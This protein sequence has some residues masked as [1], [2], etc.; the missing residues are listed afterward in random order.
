[1]DN[2]Y[3]SD[4]PYAM[5]TTM[6]GSGMSGSAVGG[7][8][9]SFAGGMGA[10]STAPVKDVTT[11]TFMT[12]VID[13][14][15]HGPVVV[16]FW[17]PWCG[18]CKDL[19]PV[20]ERVVTEVAATGRNITLAKMDV[21][22]HPQV[23]QQMGIQSIPAVV[24]FVDGRPAE[25]FMGNKP[26]AEVRA[27]IE[28][29][30]GPTTVA[31]DAAALMEEADRAVV[32]K[33]HERAAEIYAAVLA[34]EPGNL[35]AFAGLGQ[36]YIAVGEPDMAAALL[37]KI[38]EEHHAEGPL[39]SL[40]KA[41]D[42]ARQAADLGDLG[43]LAAAVEA[44]PD[45]H[46]ARFDYALALNGHGEREQATQ[47]LVAIVKADR[48]WREDGARTQLLEF[49]ETWGPMDPA[50]KAGRRALSSVLFS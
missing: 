20:I 33:D 14:S 48:E 45:N 6:G 10:T 28:K 22:A 46:E 29:V 16:D 25:A 21:E 43:T 15:R 13:A 8:G 5:N 17:A 38:P 7:A 18:P 41:V 11:A 26:E 9:A 23:S 35:D 42:L 37:E 39:A 19:G 32:E 1:M 49:F 50:T 44:A 31:A 34:R 40:K 27:F 2:E 30:A 12:D 47:Q 36:C 24:A 3:K 4:Q